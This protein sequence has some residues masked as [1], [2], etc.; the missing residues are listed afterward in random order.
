[1]NAPT[2]AT[3]QHHK[4][5][6][7]RNLHEKHDTIVDAIAAVTRKSPLAT[8]LIHDNSSCTYA[9]LETYSDQIAARLIEV[10]IQQGDGVALC[11]D[12][13]IQAIAAMLGVFKAGAFFVPLDPTFPPDRA[14]YTIED[15]DIRAL[16][17]STANQS[18]FQFT[19]LP[20]V[21]PGDMPVTTQKAL[22]DLP[23]PDAD[24]RAYVMYTSGS[25]GKPK[26]VAISHGALFNYCIADASI[27]KLQAKDRTLQ[28]S[29]L[30]F[31]IAIEE[32]FPPLMVGS[33]VVV[34]PSERSNTQIELSDIVE[35]YSITALHLATGYWHEWVDLMSAANVKASP[36]IRLMVVTGE[37][38][39]PEH[40]QRW[41]SLV[42]EPVLWANAYGPTE[43][44]VSATVFIPPPGWHGKSMPIGKPL[45]NYSAYILDENGRQ[46][47]THETGELFIGGSSLAEGYLN[48]PD[49]TD[50]VFVSDPFSTNQ[51][52]RMYRTG[53]LARWLP[54]G[55]IE[56]AGRIDHQ[57]KVGSY[58]IEP[59][60]IENAINEHEQVK[61]A[62]VV[63]E[64]VNN[65][66]LL[67]AYIASDY[68][69]LT[70][71]TLS[72]LGIPLVGT[73]DSFVSLG[74]DSLLAVKTI[75]RIQS[76]LSFTIST[77]D[78]F[79]L[80]TVALLAG[81]IEGKA[82]SRIVPAPDTRYITKKGRQIY[83][84]LQPADQ[85]SNKHIG[86]LLVP[87]LGN[88]NRRAQRP[89][90]ILTQ[91]LAR[92]GFT[93]LRFDWTGTGNS[94]GL[95]EDIDSATQWADDIRDAA[96]Q[97]A[98]QCNQINIVAI[99]AGAFIAAQA[100]L[101][102]LPV[103]RRYYWD[104]ILSAKQWLDEMATLQTGILNDAYRFLRKR[105]HAKGVPNEFA[106][107]ILNEKLQSS[108]S[109]QTMVQLLCEH[110]WNSDA[111]CYQVIC[112]R[113]I[114][115]QVICA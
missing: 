24:D 102:E 23:L 113:V 86:V 72:I 8:A 107:L 81:Y 101:Q 64:E 59:G 45:H 10:N 52:A 56:Y 20:V 25:T 17:C 105:N 115:I 6:G 109:S 70:A 88:E 43:T 96:I 16:L 46:L 49:L 37:K 74:G 112:T 91:N 79:Y 30:A 22:T 1:M 35:K 39:S 50:E 53:D 89:L 68:E 108:L 55:N 65:K 114:C 84:V 14:A 63:A 93:S 44:T 99:R 76:D 27:F 82:V 48:K 28:F 103:Q 92:L 100:E 104:P 62:L 75:S 34:R 41:Q 106:G 95:S 87:P 66:K 97:L 98:K 90:R 11:L 36:D 67:L 9:Q 12:R 51:G 29:T 40:Y 110:T 26:G 4:Q 38:V 71:S 21:L 80:D 69:H 3:A 31:D 7:I 15:A 60:E 57:L 61:E 85:E 2:L 19:N 13:S 83:T 42:S 18:D 58:R 78:F 33:T 54:D 73:S 94:S 111:H 47:G 77:R 5:S 32:I